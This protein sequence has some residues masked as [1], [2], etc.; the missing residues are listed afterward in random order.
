MT[1]S[2]KT[3]SALLASAIS[4]LLCIAMLIGATFAWF[5]DTAQT[6]VNKIQS[7]KLDV[8]LEMKDDEGDWVSAEGERL[9][10]LKATDG[11]EQSILWEPGCTYNLP[12]LR[13]RNNGN[14]A[15]K[16]KV[17]ITGIEGNAKLNEAIEWTIGDVAQGEEQS[18]GAGESN[19]FTISGH[20]KEDAGND[21]MNLSISS[22]SI[23][24]YATQDTVEYDST[25]NQYDEDATYYINETG[26]KNGT[27]YNAT[28]VAL[29]SYVVRHEYNGA[30]SD[31]SVFYLYNGAELTVDNM[32]FSTTVKNDSGKRNIGFYLY[33]GSKLTINSGDF[34]MDG[35]WDA[36]IW[37]QGG[38]N[39][40]AR[41][42]V[43]INGGTFTV[44]GGRSST[45]VNAYSYHSSTLDYSGSDIYIT[46]GFFDLSGANANVTL[47]WKSDCTMRVTGGTFV[48]Y[49][50]VAHGVVPSGYRVETQTQSNGNTWYTVVPEA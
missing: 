31:G 34:T 45:I 14:L 41:C 48:N 24:V 5:T 22:I 13:I 29:D 10:F 33:N 8:V 9:S 49:N 47:Q 4:L 40:G 3:K 18:L 17:V 50:P 42:T 11:S 7:G 28:K 36:F 27:V 21:Y 44:R 6:G 38:A 16:Y 23:T 39:G 26:K 43:T 32:D 37:A 25:T 20:M 12:K 15:L 2:K 30:E 46:G 19:E 1:K 35:Q